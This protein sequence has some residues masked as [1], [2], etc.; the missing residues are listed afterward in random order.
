LIF[1]SV[2]REDANI[3]IAGNETIHQVDGYFVLVMV[4]ENDSPF[5][6]TAW[7][8]HGELNVNFTESFFQLLDI[9]RPALAIAGLR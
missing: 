3:G 7:Q 2:L 1:I 6:A 4:F 9:G 8:I 5:G